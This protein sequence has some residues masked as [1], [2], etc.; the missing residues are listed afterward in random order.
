VNAFD[1]VVPH[2]RAISDFGMAFDSCQNEAVANGQVALT[3]YPIVIWA[4][5]QESTA[6]ET[7]S[8]AEQARVAEFRNGNGNFFVSGSEIA[9]D[10]DRASGPTAADRAFFE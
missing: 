5:G 8:A 3:A 6:D 4:S 7:F 1:Y 10:L 9:W 2:G